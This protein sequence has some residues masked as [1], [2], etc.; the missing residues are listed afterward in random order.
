MEAMMVSSHSLSAQLD[1]IAADPSPAA[2]ARL[3]SI[4]AMVARME[5]ALDEQVA[6]AMSDWRTGEAARV[7]RHGRFDLVAGG[8]A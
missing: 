5:R 4:A 7:Q 1:A 8:R 3:L 6:N 2:I